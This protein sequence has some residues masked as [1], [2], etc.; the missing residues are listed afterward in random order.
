LAL[1]AGQVPLAADVSPRTPHLASVDT[2]PSAEFGRYLAT[3][4]GCQ[5]CHGNSYSGGTGPSGAPVSNIT[6]TGIGHYSED[7]FTRL[8]RT[9]VR[10]GGVTVNDEMPWKFYRR[11]TDGELHA[12]WLFLKTVPPK[13]FGEP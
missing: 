6:P 13:K 4:S 5:G 12:I 10:P 8:I 7:D 3:V 2:T 11:M 1:G 9:G